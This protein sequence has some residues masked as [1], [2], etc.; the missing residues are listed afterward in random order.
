MSLLLAVD[1]KGHKL[2]FDWTWLLEQK[3]LSL[4]FCFVSRWCPFLY[5][6]G[7]PKL[8]SKSTFNILKLIHSRA[9]SFMCMVVFAIPSSTS[10]IIPM[11][12]T[13]LQDPTSSSSFP[14]TF[15]LSTPHHIP[16]LVHDHHPSPHNASV[17]LK[18]S[19]SPLFASFFR[20]I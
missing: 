17:I 6:H 19:P 11:H 13:S 16:I 3:A 12:I 7:Y 10:S 5:M 2:G 14:T 8:F 15:S 1:I 18:P 4:F 9:W 20:H